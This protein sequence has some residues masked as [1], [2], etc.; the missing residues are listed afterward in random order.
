MRR[1]G[2]TRRFF[3]YYYASGSGGVGSGLRTQIFPK[4]YGWA[5]AKARPFL[6]PTANVG[7]TAAAAR[8]TK[9]C[10]AESLSYARGPRLTTRTKHP[11]N[12]S[13]NATRATEC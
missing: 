13:P 3:N 4:I 6:R 11:K 7:E 9:N 12:D 5:S 2:G 10:L 8:T 1:S